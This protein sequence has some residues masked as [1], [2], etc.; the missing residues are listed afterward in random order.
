MRA[1]RA[2]VV[3][4][5]MM[6]CGIGRAAQSTKVELS[7][8]VSDPA[9]LPIA[10]A[11]VRLL[12]VGTEAERSVVTDGDGRYHFF[13]LQPGTYTITVTKTG[14]SALKPRRRCLAGGRSGRYSISRSRSAMSR[15]P[16]TSPRRRRYCSPAGARSVT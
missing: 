3:L 7:G 13:A 12:N 10:G 4:L 8:L 6:Q 1:L 14:F 11:A 2:T 16:S 5:L 15:N 9:G